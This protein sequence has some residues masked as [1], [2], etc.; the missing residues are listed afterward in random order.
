MRFKTFSLVLQ[1]ERR[2]AEMGTTKLIPLDTVVLN[3]SL[4]MAI[5]FA[6]TGAGNQPRRYQLGKTTRSHNLL[7]S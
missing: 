7:R 6:L 1:N 5:L 2:E 3:K 4:Y